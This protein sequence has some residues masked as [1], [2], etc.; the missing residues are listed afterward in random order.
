MNDPS[1]WGEEE[2]GVCRAGEMG[3]MIRTCFTEQLNP[4][5]K[6]KKMKKCSEKGDCQEVNRRSDSHTKGQGIC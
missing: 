1:P 2:P 5:A 6:Q 4:D 3:M